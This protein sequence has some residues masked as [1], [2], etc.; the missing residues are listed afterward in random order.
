M[1]EERKGGLGLTNK[2]SSKLDASASFVRMLARCKYFF[3]FRNKKACFGRADF[4][5]VIIP[6]GIIVSII[7][8]RTAGVPPPPNSAAQKWGVR[9]KTWDVE[10]K[11]VLTKWLRLPLILGF[12]CH[13]LNGCAPHPI[14]NL[15]SN[16]TPIT[17]IELFLKD[18]AQRVL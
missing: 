11:I 2:A 13:Q 16:A 4:F 14:F 9:A 17:G 5:S 18:R 6:A 15:K 8:Q 7:S 1:R 12:G 10:S 3:S